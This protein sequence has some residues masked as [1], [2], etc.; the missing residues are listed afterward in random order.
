MR[1]T[2]SKGVNKYSDPQSFQNDSKESQLKATKISGKSLPNS[3]ML[4]LEETF[5]DEDIFGSSF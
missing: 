2:S 5:M 1:Q 4:S 3:Q